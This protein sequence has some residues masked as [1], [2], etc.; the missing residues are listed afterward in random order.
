MFANDMA[1]VVYSREKLPVGFWV[2]ANV[3]KEKVE[4]QWE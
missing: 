3:L 4:S 2:W 1:L